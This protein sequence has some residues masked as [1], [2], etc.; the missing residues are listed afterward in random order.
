M[1]CSSSSEGGTHSLKLKTQ[2][3]PLT[4]ATTSLSISKP[5]SHPSCPRLP[6][7]QTPISNLVP[8]R[9]MTN[10]QEAEL[11]Q[12]KSDKALLDSASAEGTSPPTKQRPSTLTRHS[13]LP[14]PRHPLLKPQAHNAPLCPPIPG[15]PCCGLQTRPPHLVLRCPRS[16]L[17]P[18]P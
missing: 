7:K 1:L 16:S 15:S 18:E 14:V 2:L 12:F 11:S 10:C 6:P 17:S 3:L 5:L 8:L 9:S 4:P 13:R